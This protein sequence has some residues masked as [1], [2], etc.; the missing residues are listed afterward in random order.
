M[1]TVG[2]ALSL[3]VNAPP[4]DPLTVSR[5]FIPDFQLDS[6]LEKQENAPVYKIDYSDVAA[7]PEVAG[8][9]LKRLVGERGFEPPTPSSRTRLSSPER[10]A[11]AAAVLRKLSTR[12]RASS[13]LLNLAHRPHYCSTAV[14]KQRGAHHRS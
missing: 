13:A 4:G 14:S 1:S 10:L 12:R 7:K 2:D 9:L 11:N 6:Q 8:K 5:L 3:L